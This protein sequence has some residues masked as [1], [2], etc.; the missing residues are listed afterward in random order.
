M[1]L[2]ALVGVSLALGGLSML[3]YAHD[4]I[5]RRLVSLEARVMALEARQSRLQRLVEKGWSQSL[6]L[7]SFD[8]SL[9][10]DGDPPEEG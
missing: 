10:R 8:W 2:F 7:T 4:R 1:S 3:S 6:D 5:S 9:R